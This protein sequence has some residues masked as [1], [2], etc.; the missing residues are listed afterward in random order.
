MSVIPNRKSRKVILPPLPSIPPKELHIN[1][2][3]KIAMFAGSFDPIHLGHLDI[4][5]KAA[6]MFDTLYVAVIINSSKKTLLTIDERACLIYNQNLP[7]NVSVITSSRL[8]VDLCIFH[9]AK[10]LIRGVRNI[11]DFEYELV[12]SQLNHNLSPEI[13]TIF[14]PTTV[15]NAIISSSAV[16]EIARFGGDISEYVPENVAKQIYNKLCAD[17]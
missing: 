15:E 17:G 11:I 12:M 8:L 14:I 4:I 3:S 6:T 5:N 16:K 1:K 9:N 7:S 13:Q 2:I 10:F